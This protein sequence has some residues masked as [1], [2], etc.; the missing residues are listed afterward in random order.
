VFEDR[1]GLTEMDVIEQVVLYFIFVTG[2]LSLSR[3]I[4]YIYPLAIPASFVSYSSFWFI[5]RI[6]DIL[7]S[8][9]VLYVIGE[10]TC[11]SEYARR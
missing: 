11:L 7:P 2:I 5:V 4:L 6:V 9:F 1:N 10:I 3:C 8:G